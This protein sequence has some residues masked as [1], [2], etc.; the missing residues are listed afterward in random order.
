MSLYNGYICELGAWYGDT[1]EPAAHPARWI[2]L[3]GASYAGIQTPSGQRMGVLPADGG[4]LALEWRVT[5]PFD[6]SGAI[7][8]L[9]QDSQMPLDWLEVEE[10][11][12]GVYRSLGLILPDREP[13]TVRAVYTGQTLS[14]GQLELRALVQ[15][16]A[17]RSYT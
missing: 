8:L 2:G 12:T 5:E 15:P 11:K 1:F 6:E 7:A 13:E 3:G 14:A 16:R 10:E 17:G 4:V 9:G